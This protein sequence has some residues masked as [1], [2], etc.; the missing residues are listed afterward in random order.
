M[1]SINPNTKYNLNTPPHQK[2][3]AYNA[4]YPVS[5]AQSVSEKLRSP[6]LPVAQV[7]LDPYSTVRVTL[8]LPLA[9]P[10]PAFTDALANPSPAQ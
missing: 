2:K 3:I 1:P 8:Y 9:L 7:T 10:F 6:E 5:V 4:S